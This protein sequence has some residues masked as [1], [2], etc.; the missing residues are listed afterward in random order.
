MAK[1]KKKKQTNSSSNQS[2][3]FQ[4]HDE[5]DMMSSSELNKR[6]K[7]ARQQEKTMSSYYKSK[8]QA[9]P[10][11]KE[12]TYKKPKT[13]LYNAPNRKN[14]P[15]S[16]DGAK[17]STQNKVRKLQKEADSAE[18]VGP[19]EKKKANKI[20]QPSLTGGTIYDASKP[21]ITKQ[22]QTKAK[23]K[24]ANKTV[25]NPATHDA[26]F[27]EQK[28]Q[29]IRTR[30]DQ[31]PNSVSKNELLFAMDKIPFIPKNEYKY[32]KEYS[33]K[34]NKEKIANYT[35]A[36]NK[37]N[38]EKLKKYN[39][40][41][42]YDK[43]LGKEN[44]KSPTYK[45]TYYSGTDVEKMS[46]SDI[47]KL[48][49]AKKEGK[50]KSIIRW[51]DTQ[52]EVSTDKAIKLAKS[53]WQQFKFNSKHKSA[54][55]N[56][57]DRG[58][59]TGKRL[60]DALMTTQQATQQ[61]YK[62]FRDETGID[63]LKFTAPFLKTT[64][65]ALSDAGKIAMS[66]LNYAGNKV[67][68]GWIKK[69]D[70]LHDLS[71]SEKNLEKS[72]KGDAKSIAMAKAEYKDIK[73]NKRLQNVKWEDLKGTGKE[74]FKGAK[75][76]LDG[77]Y[78]KFDKMRTSGT[79]LL[80]EEGFNKKDDSTKAAGFALDLL[81]GFNPVSF[82]GKTTVSKGGELL[83]KNKF[84]TKKFEEAMIKR[85]GGAKNYN[86]ETPLGK[87][88]RKIVEDMKSKKKLSSDDINSIFSAT[89]NEDFLKK[90]PNYLG[91]RFKSDVMDTKTRLLD[92]KATRFDGFEVPQGKMSKRY[93]DALSRAN[94]QLKD[95]PESVFKDTKQSRSLR[96]QMA[97]KG[98]VNED[99]IRNFAMEKT[100]NAQREKLIKKIEDLQAKGQETLAKNQDVLTKRT[101][102]RN[103]SEI[104]RLFNAVGKSRQ[105]ADKQRGIEDAFKRGYDENYAKQYD[106]MNQW[107]K[108]GVMGPVQY[109]K[110]INLFGKEI[111]NRDA[112]MKIPG[113]KQAGNTIGNSR[114]YNKFNDLFN[115]QAGA[116]AQILDKMKDNMG[117]ANYEIGKR[118][119]ELQKLL[120]GSSAKDLKDLAYH[121]VRPGDEYKLPE[122][123]TNN[124]DDIKAFR[125][126]SYTR[127]KGVID[128]YGLNNT[129]SYRPNY[130]PGIYKNNEQALEKVFG[131]GYA[132]R[133]YLNSHTGKKYMDFIEAAQ[134]NP[135]LKPVTDAGKLLMKRE[136]DS[137]KWSKKQE[138]DQ[139]VKNMQEQA[140]EL[141]NQQTL[142][143]V[144]EYIN[145]GK[146]A[147]NPR[148][149]IGTAVKNYQ[150]WWKV[151]TMNT[152]ADTGMRN[153]YGGAV[154]NWLD[155]VGIKDYARAL[156]MVGKSDSKF[157]RAMNKLNEKTGGRLG[158]P[159]AITLKDG[160]T[161][162]REQFEEMATK[163]GIDQGLM[164]VDMGDELLNGASFGK[165]RKRD[166]LNP[167]DKDN[168]IGFEPGKAV[169]SGVE[170]FL[171][172]AR[173]IKGLDD[174][175]KTGAKEAARDVRKTQFDYNTQ[176]LTNTEKTLRDYYVPF[177][178]FQ[179]NNLPF[180]A[181]KMVE[182]PNRF[183]IMANT[184][185]NQFNQDDPNKDNM[186]KADYLR[187]YWYRGNDEEGN[188]LYTS[189]NWNSTNDFKDWFNLEQKGIGMTSP[190]IKAALDYSN[191]N[192][193]N[194]SG[195]DISGDRRSM[196]GNKVSGWINRFAP[197][198]A[199]EKLGMYQ[200]DDGNYYQNAQAQQVLQ[201]VIPLSMDATSLTKAYDDN[202]NKATGDTNWGEFVK[203]PAVYGQFGGITTKP[204]KLKDQEM[205][206]TQNMAK[207]M[208]QMG[209][210]MGIKENPD[211]NPYAATQ[212][213]I[214]PWDFERAYQEMV[215]YK[216]G[217]Y[218]SEKW[219]SPTV[220]GY[221]F[222]DKYNTVKMSKY[223]NPVELNIKFP[224]PR[225][226]KQ[227]DYYQA[228]RDYVEEG[229][230]KEQID[231]HTKELLDNGELTV[232]DL[233]DMEGIPYPYQNAYQKS[234]QEA[235]LLKEPDWKK[236]LKQ[237][238]K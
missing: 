199:K 60:L 195:M 87:S 184:L 55:E 99:L 230:K 203:N 92:N 20:K 173:F 107:L 106:N 31:D 41:K 26:Y 136:G 135:S 52:I 84:Q 51:N 147:R 63:A 6:A 50:K 112:L 116:N 233:F 171:R 234:L 118:T 108:D 83:A 237:M 139:W 127:D 76:S 215:K 27:R 115:K 49:K 86:A 126:A 201:D 95:M 197:D 18:F 40:L 11:T 179:R 150:D 16:V 170:K 133:D 111:V 45:K 213:E 77:T 131:K 28:K 227:A 42:T 219:M 159:N 226:Q 158:N 64:G 210:D 61:G 175:G 191:Q 128:K 138:F 25:E 130:L 54:W 69:K 232:K 137:I 79:D 224:N 180:Q 109:N 15:L 149:R 37:Q 78:T 24:K 8:P 122:Q 178:T 196:F 82:G 141:F 169:N 72:L 21:L 59:H 1:K 211:Y 48:E 163:G 89:K 186:Y 120:K 220:P 160:T 13:P 143:N 207:K 30:F 202:T 56:T 68:G 12:Y 204:A 129:L 103:A 161:I 183:N 172:N 17:Y 155:G 97:E 14:Y 104:D 36:I 153:L 34:K 98:N 221:N 134:V 65:D 91:D 238:K 166:L 9:L 33:T 188:P 228:L 225:N 123:F 46:K 74:A 162:S 67:T 39:G 145:P 29:Q 117:E 71:F 4:K 62:K 231:L 80:A 185:N 121:L 101:D 2:I 114:V 19:N 23:K 73:D 124:I 102:A 236:L 181:R 146:Y 119:E 168:F 100:P 70:Y 57:K 187:D 193:E 174:Y 206:Y 35:E 192:K 223:G 144:D 132:S 177:Y 47:Q 165:K 110:G 58:V 156:N 198:F 105:S 43:S 209:R 216:D 148:G 3:M 10:V 214:P 93:E 96:K 152:F 222:P 208:E 218:D 44:F 164:N 235:E 200:G 167:F 194:T 217:R 229:R 5:W 90:N 94:L 176:N 75:R 85:V 38:P 81:A 182:N 7:A 212:S 113:L 205:Y 32:S 125:D 66:P 189:T 151:A 88:A 157:T 154:N 53:D 142:R 190:L 140:P 22:D